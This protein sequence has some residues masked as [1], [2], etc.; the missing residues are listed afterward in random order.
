ML[1]R[2]SVPRRACILWASAQAAKTPP[3]HT[4]AWSGALDPPI[5]SQAGYVV[6]TPQDRL[7]HAAAD[8]GWARS[9]ARTPPSGGAAPCT[10]PPCYPAQC[11]AHK[12]QG[13]MLQLRNRLGLQAP[14][15]ARRW[16]L[17]LQ[18]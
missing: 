1:P 15:G 16:E 2:G 3:L 11:G 5:I 6:L 14:A 8:A 7:R 10:F 9:R 12:E 18:G 17:R 13:H 4:C